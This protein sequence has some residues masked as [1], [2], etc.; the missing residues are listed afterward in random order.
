MFLL[1]T[2]FA[3]VS[4]CPNPFNKHNTFVFFPNIP[5]I[6]SNIGSNPIDLVNNIINSGIS[7][8]S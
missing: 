2:Y 4:L 5:F 8:A 6:D 1:S 3:T 7:L